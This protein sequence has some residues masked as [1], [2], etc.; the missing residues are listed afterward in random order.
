[1]GRMP[2]ILVVL[3]CLAGSNL[4]ACATTNSKWTCNAKTGFC[5]DKTSAKTKVG[6][7]D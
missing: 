7:P 3:V 4:T 1:M 6:V 5:K 2:R